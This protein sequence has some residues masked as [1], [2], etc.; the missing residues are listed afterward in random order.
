MPDWS[1]QG[2]KV[3]PAAS[4]TKKPSAELVLDTKFVL[5]KPVAL[6][7]SQKIYEKVLLLSKHFE[8]F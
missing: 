3:N 5:D 4:P 6:Q 7:W 1:S 2:G 8:A